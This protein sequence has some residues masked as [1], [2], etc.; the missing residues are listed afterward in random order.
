M[1]VV[2][3]RKEILSLSPADA[4][5]LMQALVRAGKAVVALARAL[6]ELPYE[7]RA[8][9][10][11]SAKEADVLEVASLLFEV[12]LPEPLPIEDRRTLTLGQRKS[13]ARGSR[14]EVL[15]R[16]LADPDAS[17]IAILLSNP[18]L[19]ERDVVAV[20]ARRP[21]RADVIR[22]VFASRW[23]ERYAV[24]QSI[25]HNPHAPLDVALRLLTGLAHADLRRVATDPN[26]GEAL[27]QQA[28]RLMSFSR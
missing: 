16:L 1:Q 28:R 10:Y 18:R 2:V 20:A 26:V 22:A 4:V 12:P 24:K 6:D 5:A 11:A 14:R 15:S 19:T 17:V 21:V 25:I 23:V 7:R 13:L 9:L 27:R 8:Q 3:L